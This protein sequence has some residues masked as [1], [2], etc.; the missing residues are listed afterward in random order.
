MAHGD[1]SYHIEG[2]VMYV[3]LIGQFN[4]QGLHKFFQEMHAATN[5][6][7]KSITNHAVVNLS[8]WQLVTDDSKTLAKQYFENMITRGYKKVDYLMPS[9]NL[10][11]HVL[12]DTWK[13]IDIEVNFYDSIE[14]FLTVNPNC[15]YVKN[16]MFDKEEL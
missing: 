3:E 12:S 6:V 15:I 14:A 10:V 4:V 2:T 13:G 11:K 16:W 7:P 9:N 8:D 5:I 1:W